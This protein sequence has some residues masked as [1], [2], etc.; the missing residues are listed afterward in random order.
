M[1][2]RSL[3]QL[4]F[5]LIILY[6]SALCRAQDKDHQA[7]TNY[8]NCKNV[9]QFDASTPLF[10]RVQST[11]VD[12]LK[13]FHDA[14]MS[15]EEHQMTKE[16]SHLV[17][18]AFE[19]LPPLHQRVLKEHLRSISFLNNMPNTALTSIIE[20]DTPVRHYH[21]TFRA[22]I[23]KQNVSEWLTEKERTCFDNKDI[24]RSVKVE[25]GKLNAIFYV[26]L[27]EATH[28][29]DGSLGLLTDLNTAEN[30][31]YNSF[32]SDFTNK[33]WKDRLN[34][35]FL[36]TDSLFAKNHFR[37]GGKLFS[38]N[39]AFDL[40]KGL[41]KTPFV[42]LY[43]SSSRHEDLAEFLTVYHI[44]RKLKQ[45][46]NIIVLEN[47]KRLLVYDPMSS[48]LVKRRTRYMSIFYTKNS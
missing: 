17:K 28:V 13:M 41:K 11:P 6:V 20:P 26:L 33:I 24:S 22:A 40:Y 12:V 25:C 2:Y 30:S 19:M 4:S 21:I 48:D 45:P 44:T 9:E 3:A 18:S 15:P 43:S 29:V 7:N 8:S 36:P 14:G 42:S 38:L 32:S 37:R 16:E 10:T 1:I 5:I 47:G 39:Q 46:F 35:D 31:T 34:F 27:H 23:L